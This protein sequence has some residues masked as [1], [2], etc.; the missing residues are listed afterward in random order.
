[1]IRPEFPHVIDSSMITTMRSCH[2]KM[3]R[4]YIEHWKIDRESV[5]LH[6]GGAFAKGLEVARESFYVNGESEDLAKGKG[7]HALLTFYGDYQPPEGS[8]KSLDRMMG[9]FEFFL[10]QYPLG[11]DGFT[12]L[13]FADNKHGIEFS[14]AEPLDIDH[15]TTG[16]PILFC[17][18]ADMLGEFA[19]GI[20]LEDDKTT[21]SLGASWANQ[22]DLRSQFTGYTWAAKKILKIPVKGVLVRGISILKTK[23]DTQQV[24]S[25]RQD[26]EIDRWEQQ[27][28][29]DIK[30]L[31]EA[32]KEGYYDY[33][34][35]YACNEYGGC[36]F[37]DIC[38]SRDPEK[39]LEANYTKRVWNPIDRK[40]MTVDEW[41][42]S[43]KGEG[44]NLDNLK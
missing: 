7:L 42:S 31:I 39:W 25:Y 36:L 21:S 29:R 2:Q 38:K 22:W 10:D 32:W 26:W 12:P 15:P 28:L 16:Q 37:R 23:Y 3:F 24:L 14:F 1:M 41:D 5:H 43:W 18:R 9:A 44:I 30:R 19:D 33:N 4:Q 35:D 27:V 13:K 8:A 34:L 40:E 6:A 11:D 17:G 20:F